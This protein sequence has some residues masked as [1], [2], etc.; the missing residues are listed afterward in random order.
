MSVLGNNAPNKMFP[1][2][3]WAGA[4]ALSVAI[5]SAA[6][7]ST[8]SLG[9]HAFWYRGPVRS[10]ALAGATVAETSQG[11]IIDNPAAGSFQRSLLSSA[12][13]Y[14][15][16]LDTN[17]ST[18]K[19]VSLKQSF[20]MIGA[21]VVPFDSLSLGT[22][23]QTLTFHSKNT[24]DTSRTLSFS[25]VISEIDFTA[26]YKVSNKLA[27]GG[28]ISSA[29]S[30]REI[31][32]GIHEEGTYSAASRATGKTTLK[33]GVLSQITPTLNLGV[34]FREH[35][36]FSLNRSGA[37]S[38][39]FFESSY[40]PQ[41]L[42]LG[43]VYRPFSAS[44]KS[45]AFSAKNFAIALQVDQYL[46]PECPDSGKIYSAPGVVFGS[47][48]SNELN[49]KET[50]IP[51][52]GIDLPVITTWFF[53]TYTRVGTYY[54]PAYLKNGKPRLHATAGAL[55]RFWYLA[56]EGAIDT[57]KNYRNWNYGVGLDFDLR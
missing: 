26:S 8:V 11:T 16:P 1:P 7:A 40:H 50:Y 20:R 12:L 30:L 13:S 10:M 2:W 5:S 35:S 31:S 38:L 28:S 49:T 27:V 32:L 57:A 19:T 45:S 48:E 33:A 43:A 14:G 44:T 47:L 36:R 9:A 21:T 15:E 46:F 53:S 37:S 34:F 51:R 4:L 25:N 41:V 22:T 39:E 54:E 42:Q 3:K 56:F 6:N 23:Y 52:V 18:P 55:V 24:P 17:I 29:D